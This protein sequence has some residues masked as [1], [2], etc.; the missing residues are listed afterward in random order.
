[1][2]LRPGT[3][4]LH[5][6]S[7]AGPSDQLQLALTPSVSVPVF[8]DAASRDPSEHTLDFTVDYELVG[9]SEPYRQSGS[10]SLQ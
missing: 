8:V 1:M 3:A 6:L 9:S 5:L 7:Q 4:Q 2:K 10:V